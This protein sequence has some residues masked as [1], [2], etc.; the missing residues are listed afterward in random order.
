MF[1]KVET[2]LC[3]DIEKS[4]YNDSKTNKG[5]VIDFPKLIPLIRKKE[6]FCTWKDYGKL[7]RLIYFDLYNYI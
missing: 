6:P 3:E 5:I 2:E 4:G 1:V 7:A